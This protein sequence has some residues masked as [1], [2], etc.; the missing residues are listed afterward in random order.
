MKRLTALLLFIPIAL[1][2]QRNYPAYLDH[3]MQAEA[4]V[5]EFTGT[6]LVS[7]K[8]GSRSVWNLIDRII[9]SGV[10]DKILVYLNKVGTPNQFLTI[11]K[12]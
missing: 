9:P 6:I 1:L 3:Y 11:S 5:H 2:A 4:K 8:G 12:P 7:Q 10:Y